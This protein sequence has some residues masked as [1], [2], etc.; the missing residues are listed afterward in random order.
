MASDRPVVVDRRRLGDQ[1]ALFWVCF[2]IFFYQ[3]GFGSVVPVLPLYVQTFGVPQ[4]LIGLTISTYGLARFLINVPTGKLSD[5]LGRRLTLVIGGV[6]TVGGNLLCAYAPGYVTFLLARFVTGA[7]AAFVIT[8]GQIVLADISTPERRGRIMAIYSGVFAFAVGAGPLPGGLLAEHF[9]LGAPFLA[10][11]ALGSCA[12]LVALFLL[13]ETRGYR[14]RATPAAP[15][16]APMPF[17]QQL[18]LLWANTGFALVSVV[19]FTTFFART[20]GVFNIIPVL[21]KDR[22]QLHPDQIGFGLSFISVAAVVLAYPSGVLVD[23]FGRK[24]VIVPSTLLAG[25]AMALFAFAP[26]YGWYLAASAVWAIG[27]GVGSGAPGAYAADS[28]PTGMNA[29]AMSTYRTFADFGYVVG[30]LL[31]GVLADTVGSLTALLG[32]AGLLLASSLL[33]TRFAPETY[34]AVRVKRAS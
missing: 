12:C 20:G 32:T 25:V 5:V 11:A 15:Q 3:L 4:S 9:G 34:A 24:S 8:A 6:I 22:I 7:G 10:F 29:A 16:V 14:T 30:P 18:R 33:F 21:A 31:L 17:V 19:S 13:P 27:L 26:T 23:T 28:A 2:L 1:H